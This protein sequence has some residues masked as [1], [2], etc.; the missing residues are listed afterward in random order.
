MA[1]VFVREESRIANNGVDGEIYVAWK[2][3]ATEEDSFVTV[4]SMLGEETAVGVCAG[5]R[6]CG[7]W[8][9]LL[10]CRTVQRR[11]RERGSGERMD[12]CGS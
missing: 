6:T 9:N 11:P 8:I 3:G 5:V 1:T 7:Q 2:N 12:R 10:I 4:V